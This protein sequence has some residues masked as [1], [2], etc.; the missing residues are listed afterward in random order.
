VYEFEGWGQA[1]E[2]AKRALAL[3]ETPKKRKKVLNHITLDQ[4]CKLT[5]QKTLILPI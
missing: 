2:I 3:F 1:A 4:A 5:L